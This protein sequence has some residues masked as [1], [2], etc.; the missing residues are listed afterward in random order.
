VA[1]SSPWGEAALSEGVTVFFTEPFVREPALLNVS[2]NLAHQ[3]WVPV[4]GTL[5]GQAD[6]LPTEMKFPTVRFHLTGVDVGQAQLKAKMFTLEGQLDWPSLVLTN[7]GAVFQ[8]G[9]TL[10]ARGQTDFNQK[11]IADA[12]IEFKGPLLQRWLPPGYAYQT[13]SFSGHAHGPWKELIHDGRVEVT[14]FTSPQF[15]PLEVQFDWK[16]EQLN[17]RSFDL[18][19]SAGMSS[20]LTH[21]ALA[22]GES[23]TNLV[24]NALTLGKNGRPLLELKNSTRVSGN[25]A[26]SSYKWRAELDSFHWVGEAGD[27]QARGTVEWPR[28]ATLEASIQKVHSDLFQD[29]LK[30]TL[31]QFDIRNLQFTA[32]WT[33]GPAMIDLQLSAAGF[34]QAGLTL[35]TEVS[36]HGD[37]KGMVISNLVVTSQT[38]SVAEARGLLPVAWTPADPTNMIFF[39]TETPLQFTVTTK[40]EAI[41]WNKLAEWTGIN[42]SEPDCQIDLAGTWASPRGEVRVSARQVQL[43][44]GPSEMPKLENLTIVIELGRER[45]RITQAKLEVQNQPVTLT[46]EMPLGQSFWTGL[47]QKKI[48]NLE[49]ATAQ[50][51]VKEAQVAA[52][53]RLLPNVLSPQGVLNLDVSLLPGGNLTGE[54]ELQ[55]GRTRPLG[56]LGPI[57]DI[58]TKMKFSGRTMQLESATANIG[59]AMVFVSGQA[60]FRGSNWLRGEIPP[61]QF[62]VLG[63][64]VPLSRQPDAIIRSDLDLSIVKT[65]GAPPIIS[66]TAVMRDSFFLRDLRDLI[67][68]NV[69]SPARRP[70]YFSVEIQPFAEWRLAARVTGTRFLKVRSTLF[71]GEVSANLRLEGTLKDPIAL[72]DI[73]IDSGLIRFP[74]ASLEVRQGFVTLTSEDPYRPQLVIAAGSRKFGYDVKMDASGP[75]DAP[76]LQFSSIPPLSSEQLVLMLTAG[77]LPKGEYTLTPQQKAQTVAVFF[78]RDLLARFGLGDESEDRLTIQSGEQI[79]EQGKPTYSLEYKLDKR[80][81]L[82]GEYDRFNAFNA[83]LKWRVYSK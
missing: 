17:L 59:G 47:K 54:L 75:V 30:S 67:P 28:K 68:G 41:F 43:R 4:Q 65:D 73:R 46:G 82:V 6:F 56:N 7:A 13:A 5:A 48:P 11:S 79:S 53:S 62:K 58:S 77:E 45:A 64:N 26:S 44:K 19:V 27:I 25:F 40:P 83:G 15:Q 10:Q 3:P 57:R 12:A 69:A 39:N 72:G 33:N 2:L 16:G 78:G 35:A 55:E 42:L 22:L 8:D 49:R 61:F 14:N 32:G 9:S 23:G 37:G 20:L 31:E 18:L 50:L 74:F 36:L 70:P 60:D 1:F 71:N 63:T 66:G 80:W 21:G 81:S 34:A 24:L 51:L 38:N 52:F 76:I 29:F